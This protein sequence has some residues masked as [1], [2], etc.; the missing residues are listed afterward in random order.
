MDKTVE[1]LQQLNA[2]ID[3]LVTQQSAIG[4]VG[5][6]AQINELAGA[7]A[8]A[9][10]EMR[11]AE[12]DSN[13]PYF[14]SR[15]A[16]LASIIKASRPALTKN[17]LSVSQQILTND[18]GS[19]T[20]HTL[21]L[22]SSGQW[23][24]TR[25]RIVPGKNDMQT[26]GSCITYLKRYAYAAL[27]G[28]VSSDEDDDGEMAMVAVRNPK[29]ADKPALSPKYDPRNEASEL[30]S[31]DQIAELEYEL[32]AYPDIAEMVLEGLKITT[33]ADMPKSLYRAS[34][35]RIKSIKMARNSK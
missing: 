26:L 1:L 34:L 30:V 13:N 31:K 7:L 8:K 32:A 23:I 12:M 18:D 3:L 5:R 4:P 19:N 25:M 20:M 22:H 17:G 10:A 28:V 24:E 27:V 16:D 9:Q 14:K 35:D 2:K 11:V 29:N 33:L 6:S 15:Y 21:L